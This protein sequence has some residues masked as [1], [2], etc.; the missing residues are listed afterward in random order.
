MIAK[1]SCPS[2]LSFIFGIIKDKDILKTGS[3]G[4]GCTVNKRV[5]VE[6]SINKKTLILFNGK[7]ISLPTVTDVIK[8][9]TD[10]NILVQIKSELPLG[11][12]FGIS[13][14][15]A[16]ACGFALNKLI[17]FQKTPFEL[18]KIAHKSEIRNRTGL[19]TVGTE[20]TG[21]FL[22][23]KSAG[24]PVTDFF[25]LP[26]EGKKL[27]ALI[28][29]KIETPSILNNNKMME[30]IT[31]SARNILKKIK[32]D[33]TLEEILAMSLEFDKESGLFDDTN[34]T[35][36][37]KDIKGNGGNACM[38]AIGQVIISNIKLKQYSK[39]QVKE[40][41]ITNSHAS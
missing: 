24:I 11:C 17:K 8:A 7:I 2:S 32:K 25:R 14:A 23:K 4:I 37:I 1:A 27:Y 15:A 40:L 3:I 10:K 36:I 35:E 29:G 21:G 30:K 22:V 20:T 9:L 6:A 34:L 13:G 31:S 26:F 41:T 28:K 33:T 12:G 18:I 19:G 5:E 38:A 16:L 39:F